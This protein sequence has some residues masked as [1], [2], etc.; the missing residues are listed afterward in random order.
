MGRTIEEVSIRRR[1]VARVVFRG[2]Q[3][4][5]A[6]SGIGPCPRWL[7]RLMDAGHDPAEFLAPGAT[8]PPA[9]ARN[10]SEDARHRSG[11]FRCPRTGSTWTG[12]GYQPAWFR[13][14]LKAGKKPE[15][16]LAPGAVIPDRFE[17][18]GR[19]TSKRG[20]AKAATSTP[21][22]PSRKRVVF[23]SP[24]GQES[25]NGKGPQPWWFQQHLR[26]RGHKASDLLSPDAVLPPRFRP[27]AADPAPR[28][29]DA[30]GKRK[31]GTRGRTVAGGH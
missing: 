23:L 14:Y 16:L 31:R 6:W 13:N 9:F 22:S 12:R 29:R 3:E 2:P 1:G 26:G 8:L 4:D 24:D 28:G 25:W 11:V 27:G 7:E 21:S 18:S 5:Q 10:R 30:A 20:G 19:G 15:D 17:K